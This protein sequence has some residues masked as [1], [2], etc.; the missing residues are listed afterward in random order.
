MNDIIRH[1]LIGLEIEVTASKNQSL[2]GIKGKIVDETKNTLRVRAN[3][4][5][6]TIMKNTIMFKANVDGKNI[7]IDGNCIMGRPED[8]IKK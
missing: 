5:V 2:V 8:R 6:L 3:S 1:E 7:E 4:R